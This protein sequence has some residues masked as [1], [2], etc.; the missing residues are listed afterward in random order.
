MTITFP[1]SLPNTTDIE[2]V[3]LRMRSQVA[4]TQS[5]FSGVQQVVKHQGQWWEMGVVLSLSNRA[6]AEE[7]LAWIASLNG[8]QNTFVMGDPLGATPRGTALGTPLVNGAS[9]TG[10]SL[11]TNGWTAGATMLTGDYIQLGSGS[12]AHL[13]KVLED[14]TADG[15]GNM[16]LDIWPDLRTS[17]GNT[18]AVVTADTVGLFRLL[19]NVH[20]W[21]VRETLYSIQ[22][23]AIEAL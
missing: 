7:W 22:F 18:D 13:H 15:S 10:N 4:I 21:L 5:P 9:Q 6:T 1:R 3:S 16:T 20:E 12:S 19:G 14:E 23:S 2:S 11:I 8:Q 17:P